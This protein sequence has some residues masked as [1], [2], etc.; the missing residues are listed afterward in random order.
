[1][2]FRPLAPIVAVI[3]VLASATA[4][5]EA[6]TPDVLYGKLKAQ[7]VRLSI[8]GTEDPKGVAIWFHG[9][10]GGVD[11]RM[12]DPWL[13]GLVRDGWIVASSDFHTHAWGN[14]KSTEDTALLIEWAEE[15]TGQPVRLFV[16]G[17]MGATVSLNAMTHGV[18]APPCWYGVKSA[19][20]P[21]KMDL[22]PGAK[23]FIREAYKGEPVPA[24]RNPALNADK[25]PSDTDYRF[26]ASREDPIVRFQEN[27]GLLY[28]NLAAR[29]ADVSLLEV[30]GA[31]DDA[32]HFNVADLVRFARTCAG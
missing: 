27:T 28:D 30:I 24:D 12:D 20:D 13:Q 8:P 7:D 31:H 21:T 11:N 3:L 19:V 4:T 17:S 9:Q 22:V 14:A 26:V 29:G 18:K 10:T 2:R 23:R 1:M 15:Q 6:P 25:F 5:A 16:S 32:S